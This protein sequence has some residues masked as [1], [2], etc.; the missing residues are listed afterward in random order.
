MKKVN[1]TLGYD[2]EKLSAIKMYMEQKNTDLLDE[3]VKA[4]DNMY[5]KHVPTNVRDFI[6]MRE[7]SKPSPKPKKPN[8]ESEVSS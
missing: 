1:I 8:V 2:D 7:K 5:T 4:I 6:E 3:L